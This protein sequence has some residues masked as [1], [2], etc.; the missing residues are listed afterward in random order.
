LS[1]KSST[2]PNFAGI[3]FHFLKES[4]LVDAFL[5]AFLHEIFPCPRHLAPTDQTRYEISHRFSRCHNRSLASLLAA[6]S[7]P[8]ESPWHFN[9][10]QII[11]ARPRGFSVDGRFIRSRRENAHITQEKLASQCGL[12]RTLIQK[13]ERGGPL[14]RSSVSSIAS[15][16]EVSENSLL[17]DEHWKKSS[18]DGVAE[19]FKPDSEPKIGNAWNQPRETLY[20]LHPQLLLVVALRSL[21]R[22]IPA[23]GPRSP[24]AA[25][26]CRNLMQGISL[27]RETLAVLLRDASPANTGH[28][29]Q[30]HADQAYLAASF[31]RPSEYDED[32][33]A[34]D[35]AFAVGIAMARILDALHI[36]VTSH[37]THKG[38]AN[39]WREV[40][41]ATS[42]CHACAHASVYL[43]VGDSFLRSATLD[44]HDVRN[45][46]ETAKILALPVWEG[47]QIPPPLELFLNRFI[48]IQHF[49]PS[50][51]TSWL[52]WSRTGFV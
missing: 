16:L 5:S 15:A 13:A 29:I 45:T 6:Q 35:T 32:F 11:M 22:I 52:R 48:S 26:H 28:T 3:S 39:Y 20:T 27:A 30:K 51:R 49:A 17:V 23:Y 41:F 36:E 4:F 34:A 14:S 31:A 42:A 2:T 8:T 21:A 7:R 25:K 19:Q 46:D 10:L 40:E 37:P 9:Q 50:S 33:H 38:D 18:E 44:T 1:A 43:R 12:T 47:G 24:E